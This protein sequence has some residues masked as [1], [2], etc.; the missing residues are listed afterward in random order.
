MRHLMWQ[1]LGLLLCVALLGVGCGPSKRVPSLV[2]PSDVEVEG[3]EPLKVTVTDVWKR[4]LRPEEL[5]PTD[6]AGYLWEFNV[7]IA[8]QS[9]VGVTLELL[10]LNVQN[11]WGNGWRKDKPLNLS[12]RGGAEAE[13]S[14]KGRLGSSD[15]NA[16]P[17]L[18]GVETLTLLGR[19][20]DGE[21]INFTVRVPLH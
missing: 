10:R 2:K 19:F 8:N 13:V 21:P 12:V 4:P 16:L 6:K 9:N 5:E 3:A 20:D 18:T 14:V 11:L 15:P 1:F 7:K 17:G